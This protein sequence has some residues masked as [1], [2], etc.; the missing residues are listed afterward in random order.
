VVSTF[1]GSHITFL[2]SGGHVFRE[3]VLGMWTIT[4]HIPD[5]EDTFLSCLYSGC[6]PHLIH[7]TF[8]ISYFRGGKG[9]T[10]FSVSAVFGGALLGLSVLSHLAKSLCVLLLREDTLLGV[11][12]ADGRYHIS[13]F[14]GD[15]G[16]WLEG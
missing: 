9:R 7:F 12:A 14:W 2:G 5:G 6:V 15:F 11:P 16:G 3:A 10:R 8:H 13:L 4:Y 1:S